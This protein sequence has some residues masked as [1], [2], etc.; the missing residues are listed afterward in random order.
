MTVIL[1]SRKIEI[2]EVDDGMTNDEIGWVRKMYKLPDEVTDQRIAEVFR[3]LGTGG[4]HITLRERVGNELVKEIL[5]YEVVTEFY[6]KSVILQNQYEIRSQRSCEELFVDGYY[7]ACCVMSRSCAE[8]LLQDLCLELLNTEGTKEERETISKITNIGWNPGVKEM[9]SAL[10][11]QLAADERKDLDVLFKNGDWVV[12]HRYD[13]IT[14]KQMAEKYDM[15]MPLF[16]INTGTKRLE[17]IPAH[18]RSTLEW[19]RPWE[20]RRMALE[21]LRALYRM[22]Y[23]RRAIDSEEAKSLLTAEALSGK[24]PAPRKDR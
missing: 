6:D 18:E 2:H 3:I 8:Y 1:K 10:G 23:R 12:H 16:R 17:V 4:F 24:F 21:S 19:N 9:L 5:F 14:G 20:E 11:D 15:K 13:E 22:I 7:D